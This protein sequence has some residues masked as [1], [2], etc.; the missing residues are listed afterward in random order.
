VNGVVMGVV[1]VHMITGRASG[2]CGFRLSDCILMF[3][4]EHAQDALLLSLLHR[5]CNNTLCTSL[6]SHLPQ[7]RPA[8]REVIAAFAGATC[9]STQ[10]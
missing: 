1:T 10:T 4:A 7:A 5:S 3:G 9:I 8:F 2:T 6:A